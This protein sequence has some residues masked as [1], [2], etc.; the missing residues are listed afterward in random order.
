MS[1]AG[2]AVLEVGGEDLAAGGQLGDDE[3][4]QDNAPGTLAE[5]QVHRGLFALLVEGGELDDDRAALGR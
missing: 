2:R 4:V 1:E 5:T 3:V